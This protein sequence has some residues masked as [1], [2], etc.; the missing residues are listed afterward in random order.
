MD[1]E[2]RNKESKLIGGHVGKGVNECRH[3]FVVAV[4][5]VF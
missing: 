4:V 3:G 1:P 2:R 5:D